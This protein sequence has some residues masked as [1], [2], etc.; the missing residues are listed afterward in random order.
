MRVPS[1]EVQNNFGRFLNLVCD[2]EEIIV[3]RNG[4]DIVKLVSCCDGSIVAEGAAEYA[5]DHQKVTHEEFLKLTE[6]SEL[7]Y[8]LI[9]GEVYILAA[10]N[11]RHQITVT[12]ILVKFSNWFK[13]KTCRAITSP[14]DVTLFKG[15]DD[16]NV[17]QPDIVVI[18]DAEKVDEKGKYRGTPTLVV[19][20]LSGS[21]RRKDM[22]KKT[23]L[24]MQSGVREYWMVDPDKQ[25]VYQ[26]SFNEQDIQDY[27]VYTGDATIESL[28]FTGL[29]IPLKE[30]FAD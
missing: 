17:V 1:T 7:R 3:T 11:Y 10:P 13:G 9:D 21:T 24:Y 16:A 14:F 5:G 25:S 8:E 6:N 30:L 29:D 22:V 15:E 27:R 28:S 18:C 19:E 20:V 4:K 23:D 2:G 12:E 26:Y